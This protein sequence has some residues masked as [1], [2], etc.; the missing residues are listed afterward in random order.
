[1]SAVVARSIDAKVST[2]TK[3]YK[4]SGRREGH[5][6]AGRARP[7]R[8]DATVELDQSICP[9]CGGVLSENHTDSYTRVVED[10]VPGRVVVTEYVVRRYC[11]TCRRQVSPAIPNVIDGGSNERFGLRL[12]LLV[13]SL[14]LLGVSYEGIGCGRR[15]LNPGLW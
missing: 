13:I 7:E 1:M 12:M 5:E 11:C 9:R 4:K 2:G 3:R 10:I 14:K 8:I 6:G 15:D